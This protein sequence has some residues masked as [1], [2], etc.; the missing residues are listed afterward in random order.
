MK[1]RSVLVCCWIGTCV[2][3]VLGGASQ[4][5]AGSIYANNATSGT[6][7]VYV[8]DP[9]TLAVTDEITNL[10]SVNGRGVV[11]VN[12]IMYY[13]SASSASVFSYNLSTHTN[14]GPLFTVAGASALSTMA[15]DGTDFWIGDYSGTNQAYLYSPTG[16]LLNT[17]HLTDCGGFCDGLEFF[18][19]NG[20]GR[21]ISNRGDEL[22]PNTYDIYDTSGNLLQAGFIHTTFAGT[23]IAF[24]GTNFLVS[25]ISNGKIATYNGTTGAFISDTSINGFRNSPLVEDL[26]VDYALVLP[27]PTVPEPSTFGLLGGGL[28]AVAFAAKRRKKAKV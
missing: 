11:V 28:I 26:S 24:D 18:L 1:S 2:A 15:F 27:P 9:T 13:T 19:Q 4:A 25:E 20:Q 7:Y 14:N 16:T 8:L 22:N 12:G 10:S 5:L 3:C 17:V 6:P 21:L 23:G